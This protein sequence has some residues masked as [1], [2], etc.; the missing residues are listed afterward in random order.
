[1]SAPVADAACHR[2]SR[3]VFSRLPP[4]QKSLSGLLRPR[5]TGRDLE[6]DLLP[7]PVE[8]GEKT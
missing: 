6:I 1:M 2:G 8:T 7:L 4:R 3:F 5:L